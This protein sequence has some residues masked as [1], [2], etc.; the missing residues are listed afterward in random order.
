M[1]VGIFAMPENPSP[2]SVTDKMTIATVRSTTSRPSPV[3]AL[4]GM[5]SLVVK[6]GI[7]AD[8]RDPNPVL[9]SATAKMT[10]A[11]VRSM[12]M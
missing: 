11:T 3:K 4:V 6:M 12:K 8:V 9:K 2:K 5:G 1:A 10:I 7:G